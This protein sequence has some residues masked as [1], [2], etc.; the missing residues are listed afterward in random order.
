MTNGNGDNPITKY[1]QFIS[2]LVVIAGSWSVQQYRVEALAEEI[3]QQEDR[4]DDVRD[5]EVEA[6]V[7]M[8]EV[9]TRQEALQK[10]I[11]EIKGQLDEQDEKLDKIIDKLSKD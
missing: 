9:A 2:V 11:E 1:W 10:D 3:V 4:I 8:A 6:K 7:R 5:K